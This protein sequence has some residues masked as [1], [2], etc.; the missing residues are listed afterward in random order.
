[1][2]KTIRL[3]LKLTDA[4]I[5]SLSSVKTDLRNDSKVQALGGDVTDHTA[6]RYILFEALDGVRYSRTSEGLESLARR[7][8]L[9]GTPG[10]DKLEPEEVPAASPEVEIEDEVTDEED[11]LPVR[12][13]DR[14]IG[15]EFYDHG[16]WEFPQTQDEMHSYYEA[17]GW[18]RCAAQLEDRML[19]LYWH[20]DGAKQGLPAY[21]GK[22][23]YNRGV[24][25]QRSPDVG[26]AHMV[27]ED[28]DEP[29]G[30]T[31]DIGMWS[32]G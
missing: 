25:V 3:S 12:V 32:P 26:V 31:G 15:W 11:I 18:I 13:Y 29:R 30:A 8:A 19:E 16:G 9:L 1:M 20:P 5:T 7:D 6:L 23:S 22:D 14:P 10:H 21:D 17:A 28:W 27:P 4:Q 24:D 2:P